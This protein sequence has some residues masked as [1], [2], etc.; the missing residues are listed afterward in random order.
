MKW[1][2]ATVIAGLMIV[3]CSTRPHSV[4]IDG[5]PNLSE[6]SSGVWR[7]GQP[8]IA[9]WSHLKNI[10]VTNVIKLNPEEEASDKDAYVFGMQIRYLPVS[11][12]QQLGMSTIPKDYFHEAISSVHP[13]TYIHCYHGQDRTGLFVAMYRV[14]RDG[15]TKHFAQSEM[16]QMGFHE[17]LR[18]LAHYWEDFK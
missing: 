7:G 12:M 1:L 18:G 2:A 6:V 13:G 11:L 9:G 8:T 4:V 3:S 10:G 14:Q 17:E 16:E 15:W 5:V